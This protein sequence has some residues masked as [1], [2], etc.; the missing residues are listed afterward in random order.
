MVD[1]HIVI[2]SGLS[3][4]GKTAA[5]KLF[6]DLGYTCVDNLPGELLPDLASLDE[7]VRS[8]RWTGSRT[9]DAAELRAVQ[10]LRPRLAR[11][12]EV[13]DDAAVDIVNTL[14]RDGRDV[15]ARPQR[16]LPL[17]PRGD[18]EDDGRRAQAAR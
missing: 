7:F 3:G 18:V 5:T 13:Q 15:A 11:L 8:W 4:A 2:L 6:E 17:R 16:G 9:R 1:Q 12:W 14:L 10:G